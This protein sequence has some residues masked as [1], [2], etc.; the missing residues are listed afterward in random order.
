MEI[1]RAVGAKCADVSQELDGL[2]LA[3]KFEFQNVAEREVVAGI[4][5]QRLQRRV[6]QIAIGG[7]EPMDRQTYSR[8]GAI[9]EVARK[10]GVQNSCG[11]T[12]P[13]TQIAAE[14]QTAIR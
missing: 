5:R 12:L 11:Q 14:G 1:R 13:V 9:V 7:G 8:L 3:A 2:Q 6:M 4:E 10:A